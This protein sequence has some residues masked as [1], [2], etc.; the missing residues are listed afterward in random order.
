M[1]SIQ[2][3]E[4]DV[5]NGSLKAQ[6]GVAFMNCFNMS[7]RQTILVFDRMVGVSL[8]GV[9]FVQCFTLI[10]HIWIIRITFPIGQFVVVFGG[11]GGCH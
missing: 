6:D 1:N 11:G 5:S 2:D 10:Y 8:W 4:N 9:I 7:P 3:N